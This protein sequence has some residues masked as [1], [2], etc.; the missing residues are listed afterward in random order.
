[1]SNTIFS[2]LYGIRCDNLRIR[3][4]AFKSLDI[5]IGNLDDNVNNINDIILYDNR[6][7]YRKTGLMFM[8]NKN[9]EVYVGFK[10]PYSWESTNQKIK[11]YLEAKEYIADFVFNHFYVDISKDELI[12]RIGKF[13]DMLY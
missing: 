13:K 7:F 12:K 11:T 5:C 4:E 3:K 6:L 9:D 10:S 8:Y 2:T 1:M